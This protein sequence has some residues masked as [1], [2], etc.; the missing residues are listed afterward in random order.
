METVL[1]SRHEHLGNTTMKYPVISS[2]PQIQA[3]YMRM[4]KAGQTHNC[5]E[6]FA[7][8]TCPGLQTDTRFMSGKFGNSFFSRQLQREI[9]SR[10]DVKKAAMEQGFSVEGSV[11]Y[12]ARRDDPR[13]DELPY[14]VADDLVESYVMDVLDEHPTALLDDPELPKK[15]RTKLEGDANN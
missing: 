2:N 10:A 14:R 8:Q 13:P 12:Q 4:R 7:L 11:S 5:A 15:V 3:E 6:M 1:A 9:G